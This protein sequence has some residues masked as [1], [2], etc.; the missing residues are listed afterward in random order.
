MDT[1]TIIWIVVIAVVVLI[2]LALA[3]AMS[4][5]AKQRREDRRREQAGGV[6]RE[7]A[8][9]EGS[10]R[11]REAAAAQTDAEARRARADADARRAEAEKL[12]QRAH[13]RSQDAA[14]ARDEQHE[15]GRR[16]DEIDPDHDR[17]G[18]RQREEEDGPRRR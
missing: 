13:G 3:A 11:G 14:I 16:A 8:E 15:R 1:S 5:K 4:G 2:A 10:V 6:R 12:E 17:G 7:A 18:D 9:R